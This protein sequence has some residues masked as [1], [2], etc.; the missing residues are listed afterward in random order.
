M[1]VSAPF[2]VP[3]L[4]LLFSVVWVYS[5]PLQSHTSQHSGAG[6]SRSKK[7]KNFFLKEI[8]EELRH[9][10]FSLH[11]VAFPDGYTTVT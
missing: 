6:K 1:R 8:R 7:K 2:C 9:A 3:F 5:L 4:L 11:T 10:T